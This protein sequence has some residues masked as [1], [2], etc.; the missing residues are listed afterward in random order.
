MESK[1]IVRPTWF[2]YVLISSH[3]KMLFWLVVSTH[4]KNI[5]QNG[6]L[7]QIGLK[8]KHIWNHHLVLEIKASKLQ[9]LR[10]PTSCQYWVGI[11]FVTSH[12]V[13]NGKITSDPRYR[14]KKTQQ[15]C[16]VAV[17]IF[18][19]AFTFILY[20]LNFILIYCLEKFRKPVLK[21]SRL[22]GSTFSKEMPCHYVRF[23]A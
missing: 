2:W 7:P 11:G 20:T 21:T 23:T 3:Q 16:T 1:Q 14:W 12:L 5:S 6:N 15:P 10:V 19:N 13:H 18:K 4:L 8:I 17:K 22:F 9:Q